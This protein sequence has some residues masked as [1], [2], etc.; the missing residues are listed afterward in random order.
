MKQRKAVDVSG[1][2][3]YCGKLGTQMLFVPLAGGKV[4][5]VTAPCGVAQRLAALALPRLQA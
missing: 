1:H 2:Q 4:L 3:A 5:N